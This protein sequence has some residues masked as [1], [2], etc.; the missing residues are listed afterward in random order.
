[1]LVAGDLIIVFSDGAVMRRGEYDG[2]EWWNFYPP[3]QM[4][5]QIFPIE[6][7]FVNKL[8]E[9]EDDW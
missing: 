5:K 1:M 6:N 7:L 9:K 3:F 4:P 8:G 2:S